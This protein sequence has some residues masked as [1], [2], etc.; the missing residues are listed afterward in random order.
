MCKPITTPYEAKF[1]VN[2]PIGIDNFIRWICTIPIKYPFSNPTTH[3]QRA[4]PCGS[5]RFLTHRCWTDLPECRFVD[6]V[7]IPPRVDQSIRTTGSKFPFCFCGRNRPLAAS[8]QFLAARWVRVG[9]IRSLAKIQSRIASSSLRL[10][11]SSKALKCKPDERVVRSRNFAGSH[12]HHNMYHRMPR[13]LRVA[14]L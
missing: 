13:L 4:H 11:R 9:L 5:F 8:S 1:S 3:I 7:F 2:R 10:V 12:T 14:H 6:I